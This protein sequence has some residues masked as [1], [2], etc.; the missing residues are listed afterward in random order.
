ME[1][2][3]V[4]VVVM[5]LLVVAIESQGPPF[6][7]ERWGKRTSVKVIEMFMFYTSIQ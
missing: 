2:K 7:E 6:G 4:C 1:K 5:M 3:L